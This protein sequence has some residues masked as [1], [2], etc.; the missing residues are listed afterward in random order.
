MMTETVLVVGDGNGGNNGGAGD[1]GDG[2]VMDGGGSDIDVGDGGG[3]ALGSSSLLV[4][5]PSSIQ[6][7]T[8]HYGTLCLWCCSSQGEYIHRSLERL[9]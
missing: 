5:S 9:F 4:K 7:L 6:T 2:S 8:R 3:G 1:D